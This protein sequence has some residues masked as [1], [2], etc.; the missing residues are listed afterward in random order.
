MKKLLAL[1]IAGA[2]CV[3]LVAC[4][5]TE[6]EPVVTEQP[7]VT[8]EA[9]TEEVTEEV[10]TEEEIDDLI[11]GDDDDVVDHDGAECVCDEECEVC[12]GDCGDDCHCVCCAEDDDSDEDNGDDDDGEE[13]DDDDE[14]ELA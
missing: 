10:T 7:E 9:V 13:D 5:N 3:S 2:M 14:E 4:D 6:E 1:L 11:P 8:T 12:E